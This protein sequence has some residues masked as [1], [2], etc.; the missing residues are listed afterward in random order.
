MTCEV[1]DFL[2]MS[3]CDSPSMEAVNLGCTI[4]GVQGRAPMPLMPCSYP[5]APGSIKIKNMLQYKSSVIMS[6]QRKSMWHKISH[7]VLKLRC[8]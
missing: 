8:I 1:C 5:R 3:S 6:T 2:S 7:M 4:L